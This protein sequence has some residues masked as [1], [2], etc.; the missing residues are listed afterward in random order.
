MSSAV[1]LLDDVRASAA[2]SA[3]RI[4][5]GIAHELNTPLGALHGNHDVIRRALGR[6]QAI[7]EDEVVEPHE[8]DELRRVVRALDQVLDVNDMA[9]GR[10]VEIVGS[11]RG[12]GRP[13]RSEI[14]AVDV[15]EG[16]ESTL[17][18]VAYQT[19][20][21]IEVVRELAAVPAIECY[22]ARLNQVFMNLIVNAIQAM[23][24]GG[25]L[26]V[27]T[28]E[29]PDGIAVEVVDTGT[30]IAEA[31]LQR[32]FEPGF[33]TKGARMGMGLGLLIS[34]EIVQQHGGRL[35]VHSRPGHGSRF[36]VRL[37]HRLPLT[38]DGRVVP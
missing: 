14:Q 11:L 37:P 23:E 22:P 8:L 4:A 13:D 5:A 36:I 35:E 26:T 33:T 32:I 17:A 16:I 15:R 27:R 9:V 3:G 28:G 1:S 7:L 29:E 20:G 34:L 12:F 10:M 30:G 25:T 38:T 19:A 21:R 2:A 24:P 31:N 18:I 6:L